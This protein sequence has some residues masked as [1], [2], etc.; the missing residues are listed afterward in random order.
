[1]PTSTPDGEFQYRVTAQYMEPDG[2]LRS[3]AQV[4]LA[5]SL[6]PATVDGFLNI[7]F[8]RG[9]ASSQAYVDNFGNEPGILER[10]QIEEADVHDSVFP[11][12]DLAWWM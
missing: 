8:T 6:A 4:E 7:G 2:S 1:M 3:G 5:I 9:F 10:V 11:E 12:I